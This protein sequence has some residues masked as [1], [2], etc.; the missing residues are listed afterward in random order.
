MRMSQPMDPRRS[1]AKVRIE[2]QLDAHVRRLEKTS[3]V[4]MV[5]T[6]ADR[7]P[8]RRSPARGLA[9]LGAAPP[10]GPAGSGRRGAPARTSLVLAT[11]LG[12]R[13]ALGLEQ[14]PGVQICTVAGVLH[15]RR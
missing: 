9:P 14:L 6:E 1:K 4:V 13:V 10:G 5:P 11:K 7:Q 3:T 2:A 12:W 8:P 15:P